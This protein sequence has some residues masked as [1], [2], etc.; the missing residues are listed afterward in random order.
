VRPGIKS[1][2]RI[3]AE[4]VAI[5]EALEPGVAGELTLLSDWLRV[6]ALLSELTSQ[7]LLALDETPEDLEAGA[8]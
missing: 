7:T 6:T 1:A 4:V 3:S 2:G 5:D 8:P